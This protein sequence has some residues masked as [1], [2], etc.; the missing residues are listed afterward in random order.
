MAKVGIDHDY[1]LLAN[2]EES[3]WGQTCIVCGCSPM[4]FQWSD[5]SG[6]G[7]CTECGTPYQLK[8]G[9]DEQKAEGKYPYLR[10]KSEW[11][12][13]VREYHQQTGQFVALGCMLGQQRGMAE[14]VEWLKGHH[15]EM[16]RT[17]EQ[18]PQGATP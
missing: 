17:P 5:Y 6:E 18:E 16:L 7:M 15:P 2:Q 13:V 10:M 8:R 14:F 1:D 4:T 9:T 11:V 12:P 3:A